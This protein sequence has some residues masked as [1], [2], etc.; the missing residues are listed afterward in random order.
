MATVHESVGT[1]VV[2][3]FLAVTVV[4]ILVVMGRAIT[5][6]RELAYVAALILLIQYILGFILL[7]SGHKIPWYHYVIALCAILSVGFAHGYAQRQPTETGRSRMA[8]LGTVV[9]LVLV[10]IAYAIGQSNA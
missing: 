5:W 3:M 10:I 7:G 9:T 4:D 2:L 1:L 6:A 8:L